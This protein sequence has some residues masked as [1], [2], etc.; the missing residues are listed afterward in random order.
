MPRPVLM[1]FFDY[2]SGYLSA[3]WQALVRKAAAWRCSQRM[4]CRDLQAGGL[5]VSSWYPESDTGGQP[6]ACYME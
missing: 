4:P 1:K 2:I 6:S 5:Q 3:H